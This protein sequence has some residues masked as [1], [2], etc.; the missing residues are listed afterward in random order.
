VI[1]YAQEQN[2]ETSYAQA[3]LQETFIQTELQWKIFEVEHLI[4]TF[5]SNNNNNNIQS[6]IHKQLWQHR[7]SPIWAKTTK[8][9]HEYIS[10]M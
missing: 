10:N 7:F 3:Q 4:N 2:Q 1:S 5:C 8:V 6:W 9:S